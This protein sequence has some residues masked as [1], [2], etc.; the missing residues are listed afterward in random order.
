MILYMPFYGIIPI[1]L[2]LQPVHSTNL[3]KLM[4]NKLNIALFAGGF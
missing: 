1:L 4:S 2:G 3:K